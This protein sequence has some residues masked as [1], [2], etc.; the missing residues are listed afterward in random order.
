MAYLL[1]GSGCCPPQD[2]GGIVGYAELMLK[3]CGKY[4]VQ[5]DI[6]PNEN[7]KGRVN[8]IGPNNKKW[9]EL[10][11]DEI[12]GK[13][14]FTGLTSPLKFDIELY[15]SRLHE[16]L[17]RRTEKASSAAKNWSNMS[18][19]SGLNSE[20]MAPT[21]KVIKDP[22]KFCA[23]C[24]VT[25]ALKLCS[26]CQSIAFCCRDHQ[27]QIWPSHKADCKRIQSQRNKTKKKNGDNKLKSRV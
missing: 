19:A 6:L 26:A 1:S 27:L 11:N 8:M 22:T 9:W 16:A 21:Q 5:D 10:L 13:V 3:L 4:P 2:S 24:N 15:R 25:V 12:R 17:R 23:F 7:R 14:N 18:F 20:K